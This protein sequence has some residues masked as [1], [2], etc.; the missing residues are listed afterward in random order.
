MTDKHSA[1]EQESGTK[2]LERAVRHQHATLCCVDTLE[3]CRNYY[4]I[5]SRAELAT[6][7]DATA[8]AKLAGELAGR[9]AAVAYCNET[10]K[11]IAARRHEY[12]QEC[13]ATMRLREAESH[14][15]I[16]MDELANLP[17]TP[18]SAGVLERIKRAE[19]AQVEAAIKE[20]EIFCLACVKGLGVVI[21][22]RSGIVGLAAVH[23]NGNLCIPNTIRALIKE[24]EQ[25]AIA[26]GK[27]DA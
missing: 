1:G 17:L 15:L 4:C 3:T 10:A 19:R 7:A 12:S 13:E 21:P 22:P 11:K 24:A 14:V 23:S 20:A 25:A 26:D 9:E 5:N 6:L 16:L 18:D 2:F 8:E 27:G